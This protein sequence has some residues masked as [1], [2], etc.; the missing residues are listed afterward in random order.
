MMMLMTNMTK[1]WNGK[2]NNNECLDRIYGGKYIV[3]IFLDV[4]Q[5]ELEIVTYQTTRRL[6]RGDRRQNLT[7]QDITAIS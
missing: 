2:Q 1:I 5:C 3:T 6:I 4:A 7:S